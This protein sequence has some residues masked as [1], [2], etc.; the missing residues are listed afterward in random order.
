MSRLIFLGKSGESEELSAAPGERLSDVLRAAGIPA[1]AIL[2]KRN[3]RFVSEEALV[4]GPNDTVELLQ[5]RDYNLNVIR[6]PNRRIKAVADPVYTKSVT[7]D[8]SGTLET[9]V[10]RFDAASFCDYIEETFVQGVAAADMLRAGSDVVVGL[11]G[12]RDS[13][14]FL[15]LIQRTKERLPPFSMTAVT[16]TGLPNWD[17]PT[18]LATARKI[19][20]D[21]GIE[22]EV[23]GTDEIE[24]AFNLKNPLQDVLDQVATQEWQHFPMV[25]GHQILRRM[26]EITAA[27][28]QVSDIIFGF[29][30]D[31]LLASLVTWFTSGFQ[32]G[33]IPVRQLGAT[34]YLFPLYRITKK[35]LTLYLELLAPELSRQDTTLSSAGGA[36]ERSMVYA[37]SDWLIDLWPGIDYYAFSAFAIAQRYTRPARE[38]QCANCGVIVL[39]HEGFVNNTHCCDVCDFLVRGGFILRTDG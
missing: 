8:L 38:E 13:V 11:S 35:E 9:R 21:L 3:G 39:S 4:I 23:V 27:R 5:V 16:V 31:D 37:I 20:M 30:A 36:G 15:K 22:Q 34:R 29:N 24:Q 2:A 1:N 18:T 10:E 26:L 19:C 12:G 33:G 6:R 14:S 25:V 28:R 17:E 7:F 32:M